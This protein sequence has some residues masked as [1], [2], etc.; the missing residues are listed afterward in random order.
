MIVTA[1][2]ISTLVRL[3]QSRNAAFP[4]CVTDPGI[5]ILDKLSQ[6]ENALL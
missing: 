5:A 4:I 6:L 2:G 3:S 1:F